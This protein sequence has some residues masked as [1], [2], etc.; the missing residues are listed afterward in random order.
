MSCEKRWIYQEECR[1]F[2][3]KDVFSEPLGLMLGF[4]GSLEGFMEFGVIYHEEGDIIIIAA[5]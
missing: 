4:T 3:D 2:R 5:Q 1:R